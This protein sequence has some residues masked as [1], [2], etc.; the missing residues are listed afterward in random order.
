MGDV[1]P[2][3]GC[4]HCFRW[5]RGKWVD[6]FRSKALHVEALTLLDG[7]SG[8]GIKGVRSRSE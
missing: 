3:L 5:Q 1:T 2:I 6:S 8:S 4:K 7:S